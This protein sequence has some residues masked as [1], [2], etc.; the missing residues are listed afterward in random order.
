M[1]TRH[2]AQGILANNNVKGK[3]INDLPRVAVEFAAALLEEVKKRE[4]GNGKF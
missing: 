3:N 1:A 4:A 2:G